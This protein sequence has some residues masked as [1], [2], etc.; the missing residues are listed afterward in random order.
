MSWEPGNTERN[1]ILMTW[2]P[3]N[4]Y[5]SLTSI[6]LGRVL[7]IQSLTSTLYRDAPSPKPVQVL[8]E[9]KLLLDVAGCNEPGKSRQVG[10]RSTLRIVFVY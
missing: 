10:N 7:Y 5:K 4:R 2:E 6:A 9:F 1:T 3:G 8:Q